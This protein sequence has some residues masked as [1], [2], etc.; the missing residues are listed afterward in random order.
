MIP[1]WEAANILIHFSQTGNYTYC[2][3]TLRTN[4]SD[5]SLFFNI[6]VDILQFLIRRCKNFTNRL[7]VNIC[8]CILPLVIINGNNIGYVI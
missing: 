4:E 5:Y 8:L 2:I 3:Y 1:R 6:L 7:H